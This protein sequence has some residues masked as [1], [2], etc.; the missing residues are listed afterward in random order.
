MPGFRNNVHC[1][2]CRAGAGHLHCKGRSAGLALRGSSFVRSR[3]EAVTKCRGAERTSARPGAAPHLP[4][5]ILSPYSDGERRAASA[6]RATS[7]R[8]RDEAELGL[9]RRGSEIVGHDGRE[10]A[11]TSPGRQDFRRENPC[12]A[13]GGPEVP[14]RRGGLRGRA[15]FV[16]RGRPPAMNAGIRHEPGPIVPCLP[17]CRPTFSRVAPFIRWSSIWPRKTLVSN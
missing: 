15:G 16:S 11:P 9:F 3:G 6:S 10:I 12:R 8:T 5:G 17:S 13:S 1:G 2:I 4:A 7:K 14:L